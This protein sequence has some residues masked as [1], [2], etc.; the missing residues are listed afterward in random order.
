MTSQ[1]TIEANDDQAPAEQPAG[2][3][4]RAGV[5]M[6]P[7]GIAPFG[8][9]PV[10]APPEAIA[11]RLAFIE[12]FSP[13]LESLTRALFDAHMGDAVGPGEVLLLGEL[14]YWLLQLRT[15]GAALRG[16]TPPAGP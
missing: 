6:S 15:E 9:E 8:T 7:L 1:A 5:T 13:Q 10:A 16:T 4:A 12:R 3:A 11:R 2:I 14:Q